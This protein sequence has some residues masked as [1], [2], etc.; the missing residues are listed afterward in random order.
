MAREQ[1]CCGST[2]I[3]PASETGWTDCIPESI[4][5]SSSPWQTSLH[6]S[7]ER[8]CRA[9]TSTGQLPCQPEQASKRRLRL[10]SAEALP[11]SLTSTTSLYSFLPQG[12]PRSRKDERTVLTACQQPDPA[13][14]FFNNQATYKNQHVRILSW[15]GETIST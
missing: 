6:A 10:G 4:R 9:A 7:H 3:T 13:K 14:W 8:Y 5:T 1:P 2:A 15:P 11:L 12:L